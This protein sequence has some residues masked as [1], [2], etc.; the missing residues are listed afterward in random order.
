MYDMLEI[1]IFDTIYFLDARNK[2]GTTI[3]DVKYKVTNISTSDF[4]KI[5][6]LYWKTSF[7]FQLD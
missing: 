2:L 4:G 5:S 7:P 6:C 3:L 1:R